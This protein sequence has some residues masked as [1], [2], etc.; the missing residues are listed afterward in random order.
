MKSFNLNL[1]I[2]TFVVTTANA[3]AQESSFKSRYEDTEPSSSTS[4]LILKAGPSFS[5][6]SGMSGSVDDGFGS[7]PGSTSSRGG[8]AFGINADIVLGQN[9]S[10]ETGLEYIR[11]GF[12]VESQEMNNPVTVGVNMNNLVIPMLIKFKSGDASSTRVSFGIGPYL[13]YRMSSSITVSALDQSETVPV[14]NDDDNKLDIGARATLG[15]EFPLSPSNAFT[16]SAG[17]DFGFTD[18]TGGD[19]PSSI[20]TRSLMIQAGI[21][22][23]I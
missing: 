12:S 13:G 7:T 9:T 17:Y 2:A 14:E 22:F 16:L 21:G 3:R 4:M 23:R 20:S 10:L 1:A 6:M 15:T 19:A 11:R 5:S 18:L 8:L